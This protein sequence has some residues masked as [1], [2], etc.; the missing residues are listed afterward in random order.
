M[1]EI[2][3]LKNELAKAR[4]IIEQQKLTIKDLENQLNNA[5]S[6]NNNALTQSLNQIIYQKDQELNRLNI[7]LK[8]INNSQ[9]NKLF[10]LDQMMS[11]NFI[12][13]DQVVHYSV[14]CIKCNTFAEIE[15]KLYKEYPQYRDTNNQFLANGKEV[16]RFKTISE[17]NIG[18]GLP[19]TMIIP[20]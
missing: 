18:N 17:N 8:K 19:V 14:P 1:T 12:S 20:S 15:E 2:L 3:D 13:M 5:N 7:E 4:K 16:L 6:N 9:N 11:V 10:S